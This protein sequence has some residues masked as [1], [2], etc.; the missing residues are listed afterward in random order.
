MKKILAI[1]LALIVIAS[2]VVFVMAEDN[3]VSS[4]TLN[5]IPTILPPSEENPDV[6]AYM[7]DK[8]GEVTPVYSSQLEVISLSQASGRTDEQH[9]GRA[10]K[11]G[12]VRR[13]DNTQHR[14]DKG[15][16]AAP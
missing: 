6:L 1:A 11:V 16:A 12:D 2:S 4:V 7:L 15:R 3:Y 13:M 8:D 14:N 9:S 5:Q 10:Y